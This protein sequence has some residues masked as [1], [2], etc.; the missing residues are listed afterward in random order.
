MSDCAPIGVVAQR[1]EYA[2]KPFWRFNLTGNFQSDFNV[3]PCHNIRSWKTTCYKWGSPLFQL[4][5]APDGSFLEKTGG[6]IVLVPDGPAD[7]PALHTAA[8]CAFY[9]LPQASLVPI[10]QKCG[11]EVDHRVP[12]PD[13]LWGCIQTILEA[14]DAEVLQIMKQRLHNEKEGARNLKILSDFSEYKE[15][16][17][18]DEKTA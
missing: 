7:E 4:S 18:K 17:T 3:L 15:I 11:I 6:S 2:G 8:R 14:S 1:D 12:F 5:E 10:M 13:Y 9:D 16:M